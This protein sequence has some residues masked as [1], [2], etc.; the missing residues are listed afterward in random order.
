MEKAVTH[1]L[2]YCVL[3]GWVAALTIW[4]PIALMVIGL[5]IIAGTAPAITAV[6]Q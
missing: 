6:R 3:A 5:I 1:L 2:M 4:T